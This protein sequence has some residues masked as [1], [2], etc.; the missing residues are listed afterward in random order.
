MDNNK[1]WDASDITRDAVVGAAHAVRT[2]QE[3]ADELVHG[4]DEKWEESKPQQQKAKDELKK[5]KDRV[6]EFGQE[7][8]KGF[9]EGI[10]EVQKR[11]EKGLS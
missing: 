4:V 8:E 3:K 10:V 5:A 9:K 1:K 7:V 11:K 2:V 6:I